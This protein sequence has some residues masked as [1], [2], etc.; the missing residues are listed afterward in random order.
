MFR[1]QHLRKLGF[2]CLASFLLAVPGFAQQL[3]E[4]MV[5]HF[6]RAVEAQRAND[7]QTAETEYRLI[8]SRN[9][10]FAGAYL[11]LG[12][13]YHQQK[14]YPDAVNVLKT[15][16]QLDP[17]A[18]GSQLFLGIDEYLTGDF[19][20][21]QEH[22]RKA[23]AADP[24]DRQAGL[25]LGFDYLALDQ[26][27]QA[28]EIMRQTAKYYPSD[29]EVLYHLGEAHLKAGQQGIARMNKLG[30]QSALVFWSL[31][32]VAKQKKDT[33][34]MLEDFMKAL[35]L[36]PY[37]AEL[38]WELATTLHEK[39][40][41][42]ASAALARYQLLEPDREDIREIKT[43][44]TEVDIDEADQRSLDHLW[45]RIPEIHPKAAA[46]AVADSFVNQALA[47]REKLPGNAQLRAALH[48]YAQGKYEEAAKKLAVARAIT[49]DWS[50]SYL[51]ALS[52]ER[53]GNHEE[54]EQVFAKRL[55]PFMP[56]PSVSFLA[57][58]IE[59]VMALKCLEDVLS[60]QPDSYT[61][62]L[63]L[64]KYHAAENQDDLALAEYQ[65]AL[66]LAPN[67]LGIHLAIGTVYASQLQWPRAIEEYRAELVLDPVNSIALAQLGHALTE[68]HD[69]SSA[70]PVL[71]QALHANPSD[72]AAYIDLGKVWEM[73][74]QNDKAIQAYESALRYDPTQ[75]NLHYKLSRLYQKQGQSERAQKEL[76][77]FRAGEAQQQ[78]ND[79][80][81]MEVLQNP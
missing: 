8:T 22:L 65:E 9:P 2:L 5:S 57:V 34:G 4:W 58:R 70:G 14:K 36:D 52:Y 33:V 62:K 66:K 51:W 80:K 17:H 60:A 54:A 29:A 53:A 45:R 32:I 44:A 25:Y 16:V 38:Y 10:R 1:Y 47:E 79:R 6:N 50:W 31:A 42:I 48:L 20:S 67:Q 63:L 81:A 75:L 19:K 35:A 24:K 39:M 27:F 71:Q 76:A 40:P 21:A 61:A 11:N 12:L 43:E 15:A 41:K 55:L 37:I 78:K 23:L 72:S 56:I 28:V 7:L 68:T 13:V 77:A 74:G 26:P 46:P 69:A 18:L 73:Q 30:D 3:D 49:L 59:S 64:G